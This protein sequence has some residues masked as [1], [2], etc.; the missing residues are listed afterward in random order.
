MDRFCGHAAEAEC[1]QFN[2]IKVYPFATEGSRT[3]RRR[4]ILSAND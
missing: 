1:E 4:T 3:F 2:R